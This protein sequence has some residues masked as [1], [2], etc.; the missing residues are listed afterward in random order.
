MSHIKL[1]PQWV[2]HKWVIWYESCVRIICNTQIGFESK[3]HSH[4]IVWV[5]LCESSAWKWRHRSVEICSRRGAV[6][7]NWTFFG[8]TTNSAQA[9][10]FKLGA[11][12]FIQ[13]W[14]T[15]QPTQINTLS[16]RLVEFDI[17]WVKSIMWQKSNRVDRE[18]HLS[19]TFNP[20]FAE[21]RC[22]KF[23]VFTELNSVS[24]ALLLIQIRSKCHTQMYYSE[25]KIDE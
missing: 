7:I 25:S 10:F 20:E 16:H 1:H 4:T 23:S 2:I 15:S 6:A 8:F 18:A 24:V 19:V 17:M 21:F 13:C 9:N 12:R 22:T 14:S 5:I 11:N 3:Y